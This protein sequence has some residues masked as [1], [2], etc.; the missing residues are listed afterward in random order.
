MNRGLTLSLLLLVILVTLIVT[1]AVFGTRAAESEEALLSAASTQEESEALAA[2]CE[3]FEKHRLLYA[4]LVPLRFVVEYENALWAL[5]TAK[6][7]EGYADAH[8]RARHALLQIKRSARFDFEQ[9][10]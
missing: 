10:V 8:T 9:I 3:R 5:R 2:L 4:S 7:E 6:S 1:G